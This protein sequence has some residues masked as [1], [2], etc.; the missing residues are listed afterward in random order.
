MGPRCGGALDV[1]VVD[2]VDVGVDHR[3]RLRIRARHQHQP[4]VQHVGLQECISLGILPCLHAY[5]AS[6]YASLC[7][8]GLFPPSCCH[9]RTL[10]SHPHLQADGDE[11]LDVLLTTGHVHFHAAPAWR[12]APCHPCGRTS[13]CPASGPGRRRVLKASSS[14]ARPRCGCPRHRSRRTSS[15]ASWWQ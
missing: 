6:V 9:F 2:G 1:R 10:I 5:Q 13:W 4:G 3:G 11:P 8:C 7:L 15:P 12:Q 14:P